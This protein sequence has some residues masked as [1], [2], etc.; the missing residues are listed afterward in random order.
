[1]GEQEGEHTLLSLQVTPSPVKPLLHAQVNEPD[2]LVHIALGEQ[3]SV[4]AAHSS[5]S[6]QVNP[7]PV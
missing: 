1:L 5:M 4:L 6:E 2:V 3:L 7:V